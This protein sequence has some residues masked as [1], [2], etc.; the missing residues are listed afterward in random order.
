MSLKANQ[1]PY[2]IQLNIINHLSPKDGKNFGIFIKKENEVKKHMLTDDYICSYLG[3][4]EVQAISNILINSTIKVHGDIVINFN[5]NPL[6]PVRYNTGNGVLYLMY[7]T[8]MVKAAK[9]I[10]IKI[11]CFPDKTFSYVFKTLSKGHYLS[12]YYGIEVMFFIADDYVKKTRN[13]FVRIPYDCEDY[14]YTF[15]STMVRIISNRLQNVESMKGWKINCEYMMCNEKNHDK[16]FVNGIMSKYKTRSVDS[17]KHSFIERILYC[18]LIN[19]GYEFNIS[20]WNISSSSIRK[21][22]ALMKYNDY[23][24]IYVEETLHG[25]G[26]TNNAIHTSDVYINPS[27]YKYHE[28]M[29]PD[30]MVEEVC[31]N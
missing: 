15:V 30:L 1:L 4:K 8:D 25:Y 5:T 19:N 10:N 7:P 23:I 29:R 18:S 14:T 3:N 12:Y 16:M 11:P 28:I 6:K 2:D 27:T 17:F 9:I 22:F 24:D 31:E 21:E 20:P 26:L 13:V